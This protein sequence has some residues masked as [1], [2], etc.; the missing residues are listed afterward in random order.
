MVASWLPVSATKQH[1][2]LDL[3]MIVNLPPSKQTR[4]INSN[5]STRRIRIPQQQIPCK[6]FR[7]QRKK[8]TLCKPIPFWSQTRRDASRTHFSKTKMC[9]HGRTPTCLESTRRLSLINSTFYPHKD[10]SDKRFDNFIRIAR[11]LFKVRQKSC[12]QSDSLR[13]LIIRSGWQ[14]QWQFPKRKESGEYA[15][16]TLTS[17]MC[18]PKIAFYYRGYTKQ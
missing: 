18:A 10:L 8:I 17:T 4:L 15:W 9:L 6:P 1:E 13:K 3:A 2:R 11:K 16:I 7:F 14:T 5:Y 12:W